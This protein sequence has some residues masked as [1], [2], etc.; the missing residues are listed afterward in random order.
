MKLTHA[1]PATRFSRLEVLQVSGTLDTVFL[2][3]KNKKPAS[4]WLFV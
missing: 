4:C 3:S 1:C 2:M